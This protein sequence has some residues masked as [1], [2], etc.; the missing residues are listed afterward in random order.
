[1]NDRMFELA[2]DPDCIFALFPDGGG[3]LLSAFRPDDTRLFYPTG[4][5]NEQ[6]TDYPEIRKLSG[7]SGNLVSIYQMANSDDGYFTGYHDELTSFIRFNGYNFGGD[8]EDKTLFARFYFPAAPVS[9]FIYPIR[10]SSTIS[11]M[12]A[13]NAYILNAG[14]KTITIRGYWNGYGLLVRNFELE[15][16]YTVAFTKRTL[17][18]GQVHLELWVNGIKVGN[19]I[20]DASYNAMTDDGKRFETCALPTRNVSPLFK[21][22]FA[23][24]FDR[25]LTDTEIQ[26]Y[27]NQPVE[28]IERQVT[29][30]TWDELFDSSSEKYIGNLPSGSTVKVIPTD[31]QNT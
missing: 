1:M 2:K 20:L 26:Q 31:R 8:T 17:D 14:D 10:M 25:V 5:V 18:D 3:R 28:V 7:A 6:Y 13:L 16:W 30:G 23:M 22:D 12:F 21:Q 11:S 29:E 15:K 19:T 27:S 24:I 9:V 4:R